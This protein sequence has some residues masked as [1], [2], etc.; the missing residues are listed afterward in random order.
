MIS[1]TRL[2]LACGPY[3]RLPTAKA[4][5]SSTHALLALASLPPGPTWKEMSVQTQR[6]SA[7]GDATNPSCLGSSRSFASSSKPV[8]VDPVK[9]ILQGQTAPELG[10][11]IQQKIEMGPDLAEAAGE[12]KGEK[13]QETVHVSLN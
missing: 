9:E 8:D 6:V 3:A 5:L 4:A 11:I 2:L 10:E 12:G 13:E 1:G 7:W